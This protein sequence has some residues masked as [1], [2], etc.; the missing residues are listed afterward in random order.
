WQR[1]LSLGELESLLEEH[2]GSGDLRLVMGNTSI[3][4]YGEPAQDV[5]YGAPYIR[6]DISQIPELHGISPAVGERGDALVVGAATTYS[7]FLAYLDAQLASPTLPEPH[8]SGLAAI[9]YMAHRTAGRIVRDAASLGGNT[10]IVVQHVDS[11]KPGE[12]SDLNAPFPS[13][14]FTALTMM[15]AEVEVTCPSWQQS[16]RLKVLEFAAQWQTDQDLHNGAI[17]LRYHI[18]WS[19]E[20]EYARTFKVALREINAH[21]I[22]NAG[23]RVRLQGEVQ[24]TVA[25]ASI[26]YGGIAPIAFHCEKLEAWMIGKTWDASLLSHG[27]ELVRAE[28]LEQLAVN[29]ERMAEVPDEGFTAAYRTHLA[30]SF[31]YQYFLWL[32][33]QAGL[34]IVP[35]PLRSAG[36][37]YLRPVS[38]GKQ[39][40][41]RYKSEHPVNEAF[42]KA[43]AFI[44]ATGEAVYTHDTPVT[45]GGYEGAPVIST[46]ALAKFHFVHEGRQVG[47]EALADLLRERFADFVELVTAADVPARN[48]QAGSTSPP[49]PLICTDTVTACGQ[50]LAIV[51]AT[52]AQ[53][54][55]NIAYW[56]QTHCVAYESTGAEPVLTLAEAVKQNKLLLDSNIAA[57][58]RADSNFAWV[59]HSET[60]VNE[61]VCAVVQGEQMSHCPQMHFYL[62]TQSAVVTPKDDGGYDVLCSTQNPD[63]ILRAVSGALGLGEN[64]VD[65]RIRRVGGGYGGKGPRSPWAAANAAVAAAKIGRPVKMAMTREVDSALF[66]HE[67]PLWGSYRIAI[68]TGSDD[69]DNRGRIM[70]LDIDYKMDAGNTADCSPVV[71]DCTLL[72][73]DNGYY[74][75]NYKTSGEVYITNLASNTSFRSLDAVSG[76]IILEDGLEA[77]AHAIGMLPEDVREKNLYSLGDFTPY[78]QVLD[79]CYLRDVWNYTKHHVDF[80]ARREAIEVFN[81][82]NR[83]RKRGISM[84]PVK[85]GM[86]FNA[87]FLER[88][89]ALVDIYDSDG[90]VIVRHGGCEIGQGLNTQVMQLVA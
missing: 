49:D 86:G 44:Q 66:G 73:A 61:V 21:S 78:G 84:M 2:G 74:V 8:R 1:V 89:D 45:R 59:G 48:N 53:E 56:V 31:F 38:T 90:T 57:I 35:P 55:I 28:V 83:W 50:V 69:P 71:M 16:R 32:A 20:Y 58:T 52:T 82:H 5:C 80:E 14:M 64:Q 11:V 15:D 76:I 6:A 72:R 77:A 34:D 65:V 17:L 41:Q 51:L 26:V 62:E 47:A 25:A 87:T 67:N 30:E 42:I 27:L 33:E 36:Q 37:P 63:T 54:A 4:I 85:Y 18:P 10:M 40:Y 13:D 39:H 19:Q 22:V 88:G 75:P 60:S 9:Q 7:E 79:Y 81:R 3:G 70:G 29:A 24:P 46:R 68:G 23:M 12:C 43:E